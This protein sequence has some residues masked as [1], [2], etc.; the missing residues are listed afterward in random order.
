MAA[1]AAAAH[2]IHRPTVAA[3]AVIPRQLIAVAVAGIFR[4]ATAV[5]VAVC[6]TTQQ[7]ITVNPAALATVQ[8]PLYRSILM[9]AHPAIAVLTPVTTTTAVVVIRVSVF[10]NLCRASFFTNIP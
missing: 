6:L 2:T 8:G 1:A 3:V 4:P 7:E 5:A 10:T 9:V